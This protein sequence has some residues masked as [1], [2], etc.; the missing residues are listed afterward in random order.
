MK[1][2]SGEINND[3]NIMTIRASLEHPWTDS[4]CYFWG[5]KIYFIQGAKS[6]AKSAGDGLNYIK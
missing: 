3:S 4:D 1:G 2:K 6:N 5:V